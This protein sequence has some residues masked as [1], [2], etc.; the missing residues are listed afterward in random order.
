MTPSHRYAKTG[1]IIT[2][3]RLK[4]TGRN[5]KNKVYMTM[6]KL[7]NKIIKM[8]GGFTPEEHEKLVRLQCLFEKMCSYESILD[9]MRF[10][11]GCPAELWCK[12]I[13]VIV[14]NA[15]NFY[16]SLYKEEKNE[17]ID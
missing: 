10:M 2:E 16:N 12:K 17:R 6:N 11:Y 14:E 5:V 1:D 13:Y 8:L 15:Y 3:K 9:E 4:N 7:K